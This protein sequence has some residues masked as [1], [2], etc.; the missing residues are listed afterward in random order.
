MCHVLY[1]GNYV[2]YTAVVFEIEDTAAEVTIVEYEHT[3]EVA[4]EDTITVSIEE[5]RNMYRSFLKSGY[6]KESPSY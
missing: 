1:K 3:S 5:A 2:E 6:S 4:Y